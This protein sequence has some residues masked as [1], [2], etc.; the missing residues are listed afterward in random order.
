VELK[1][2]ANPKAV[3]IARLWALT[4]CRRNDI[5]AIKVH[6]INLERNVF[7]FDD[8]K[9]GKSRPNRRRY[10]LRPVASRL[11]SI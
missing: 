8:T 11:A 10:R 6:E 9:I 1:D 2:G 7:E 5:A 3:A 4:G